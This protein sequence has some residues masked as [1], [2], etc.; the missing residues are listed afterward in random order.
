MDVSEIIKKFE[1][2]DSH[3]ILDAVWFIL[4]STDKALLSSLST[5]IPHIKKEVNKVNLGGMFYPNKNH[6]DLA[7]A[8]IKHTQG[9]G[10]HCFIYENKPLLNPK[11]QAKKNFISIIQSTTNVELYESYFDVKCNF[12][13]KHFY[14]TETEGGHIPWYK[15]QASN[16]E[17]YK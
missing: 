3:Q 1:S 16:H 13:G 8:Y 4:D 9:G 15:W 10:C 11:A 2:Q 17:N 5:Y 6:F 14:V 7:I 12:C